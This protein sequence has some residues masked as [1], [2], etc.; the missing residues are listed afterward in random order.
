MR[1]RS[2]ETVDTGQK[3]PVR[4]HI[5]VRRG[6]GKK[7]GGKEERMLGN[8]EKSSALTWGQRNAPGC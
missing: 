3:N 4:K 7:K 1:R 8:A 6:R 5:R 2:L